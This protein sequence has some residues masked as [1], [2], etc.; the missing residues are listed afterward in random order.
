MGANPSAH[1]SKQAQE[2]ATSWTTESPNVQ[3]WMR[4]W[5]SEQEKD[6]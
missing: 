5:N 4:V 3:V 2:H 6:I 1:S